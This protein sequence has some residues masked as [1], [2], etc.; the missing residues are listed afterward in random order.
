M[1][2]IPLPEPRAGSIEFQ[3]GG[4]PEGVLAAPAGSEYVDLLTGFNYRKALGAGNTGWTI[5]ANSSASAVW[6]PPAV[7]N[8]ATVS[9]TFPANGLGIGDPVAI[10][11]SQPVPGGALLVGSV[12]A[13]NTISV[14][15]L[16]LTGATLDLD[17]GTLRADARPH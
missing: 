16:N 3:S 1:R 7:A 2:S 17:P 11:F 12:T 8:G 13:P 5:S 4:N 10:G 6:D 15:L 9:T 14:T